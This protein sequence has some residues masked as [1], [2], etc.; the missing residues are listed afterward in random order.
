MAIDAATQAALR[1]VRPIVAQHIEAAVST[2]F[3]AIMRYDEVRTAYRGVNLDDAKRSQVDHWLDVFSATFSEEEFAKA[4]EMGKRRQAMGLD[5]RWYFVFFSTILSHLVGKVAPVYRKKPERQA[6]VLSAMARAVMFDLEVFTA[7]YVRAAND[8]AGV[9]L[10]QQADV[11]ERQVSDLVRTVS[12]SVSDLRS[13]ADAMK[14][15]AD[16]SAGQSAQA[17]SA[18]EQAGGNAQT[19]AAATEEL[20]ASIQEIGR[21][22]SQS[23]QIAGSAVDEAERANTMVVGL[24]ESANRIG[25][26]VRLI[27]DIASQT[28]LLALN[29]TIEAARAGE[30]GKGFAVVAGEVKSLA[31]Q[32]ARA[33]DEISGQVAAV[34]TSTRDAVAAIQGIGTTIRRVSEIAATIAAAVEEQRAATAEIARN[35]QSVAISTGQANANMQSVST[36][37]SRTGDAAQTVQGGVGALAEQTDTLAHQVEAFLTQIRTLK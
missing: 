35:V 26:V 9:T 22:V 14:S 27:N 31:N 1:E 30:A 13:T 4:L 12:H 19:V 28:N 25:D 16:Q 8:A 36:L 33:T 3:A 15:V 5:L 10:N 17:L 7:I 11:F 29:A 20:T 23:T 37:A 18:V 2:A 34:Q 32:T 24:A 21:Q 6:E